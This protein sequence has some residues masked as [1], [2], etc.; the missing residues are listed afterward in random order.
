M[1]GNITQ[2][3]TKQLARV[4]NLQNPFKNKVQKDSK[5]RQSSNITQERTTNTPNQSKTVTIN[6]I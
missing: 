5:S 3:K 4:P 1:Q 2:N 6:D